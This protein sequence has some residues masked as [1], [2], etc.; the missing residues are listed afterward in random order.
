M[1]GDIAPLADYASLCREKRATLVVDE[2]HAV[3][4]Y[5]E[6]GS[7]LIERAG[8]DHEEIVSINTAGKALGV[9]G[10]FVA[11]PAWAIEYLVQRARTFMFSTAPPPALASAI[12]ASLTIVEEEPER[13]ARVLALARGLRD[14]LAAAGIQAAEGS[15]QI[16]PVVVGDN[17]RAVAAAA[18]L[19][20]RGF[21]VRAI[22]P[23]TVP[24]GTARLRLSVNAGLSEELLDRLVDGARRGAHGGGLLL[25]GLFVTGTDTGV[26]KTVACAALML[27]LRGGMPVRYWKP[28][29][30]GIEQDDDTAT[31]ARLSGARAA[32]I[33]TDGVRLPRPV[34][35]HL[36]A[37][38]SGATIDVA[39]VAAMA[40]ASGSSTRWIVEGAG[41]VLVPV[42]ES[43]LMIDVMA[44][45]ALPVL[46]VSR[47]TLGT[48]NH[49]LL[50]LEALRARR[51]A[52]AG[53]LM[54]GP[55]DAD[56][57]EAIEHYGRVRVVG[58]LPMLDPL[59]AGS[60]ARWAARGCD[61][62]GDL[63]EL[64]R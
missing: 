4:V 16:V 60:L 42:N 23:P 56:N 8:I 43:E 46:V 34:S 11:G 63:L 30:T 35:P 36:A 5:G 1:D 20:R 27:R 55:P 39:S 51:L 62:K 19:Q 53:V 28:I 7:G 50:T 37:R 40:G 29:Q 49:T 2:A 33:L 41:G 45:L 58:E 38:L 24:P 3:G 15:S 9:A 14:R 59:D 31:V 25:R 18:A 13:R 52:P 6:R 48:I 12:D 17:E 54:V 10:A 57:R 26:G 47:S 44:R 64:M 32:E 21:D 22:R 61:A